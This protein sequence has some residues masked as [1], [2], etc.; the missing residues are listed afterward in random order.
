MILM[1]DEMRRTQQGNNNAYCQ[2]NEINWLDWNLLDRYD[3]IHRFVKQMIR[4]RLSL[5]VFQ[6]DQGLSL[7]QL[8]QRAQI[9]WHGVKLHQPDWSDH[10]HSLAFTVQRRE[11]LFHIIFNAYRE[12]LWFDLPPSAAEARAGWRRIIDTY[13]AS[14]EDICS[15]AEAPSVEHPTYLAQPH[16][17]VLLARVL[18]R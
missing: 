11:M 8:L 9:D 16:S 10:S 2:D 12:A 18:K 3:N 13:L 15:M 4:L 7:N 14:P 6:E 1:G 17:V 5:D